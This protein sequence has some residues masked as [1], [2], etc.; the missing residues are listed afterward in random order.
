MKRPPTYQKRRGLSTR[1]WFKVCIF[2]LP[3]FGQRQLHWRH[4]PSPEAGRKDRPRGWHQGSESD[5]AAFLFASIGS[6]AA[7]NGMSAM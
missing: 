7:S 6:F 5:T 1:G 2:H 4:D 3:P